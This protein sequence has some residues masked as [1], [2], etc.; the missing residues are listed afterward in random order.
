[1]ETDEVCREG[2]NPIEPS[3]GISEFD[4]EVL[5]LNVAKLAQSLLKRLE[6]WGGAR[7][8]SRQ[9]SDPVHVS[10]LRPGVPLPVSWTREGDIKIAPPPAIVDP[11]ATVPS[12]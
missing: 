9:K 3:L 6:I 12:C 5:A 4:D 10:L 2:R 11:D 7:V 1:M 8:R